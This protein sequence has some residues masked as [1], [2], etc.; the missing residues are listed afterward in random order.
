[1]A[2]CKN[3]QFHGCSKYIDIKHHFSVSTSNKYTTQ[4]AHLAREENEIASLE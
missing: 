2:M 3:P 1:M 4:T